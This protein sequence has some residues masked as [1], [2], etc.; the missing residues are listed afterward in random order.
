MPSINIGNNMSQSG[1]HQIV[2]KQ[3]LTE[4]EKQISSAYFSSMFTLVSYDVFVFCYYYVKL[5]W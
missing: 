1:K 5:T 4:V 2:I 3:S